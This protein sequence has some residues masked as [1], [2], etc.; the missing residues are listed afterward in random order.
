MLSHKAR[1]RVIY[2]DTDRMGY[3][4]NSNYLRWFEIGR[5]ELFRFLGLT[6]MEIETKGIFMPLSEVFCKFTTPV[7]YDDL[8]LIDT[9][10][11]TTIRAGMKF[12][13]RI[14]SEDRHITHAK[15]Y[16]K[17]ACVD[18]NGRVVRPPEFLKEVIRKFDE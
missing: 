11:D 12:D 10:L 13:Y 9:T 6:Y 15:G 2:G 18:D 5:A 14:L 7:K 1:Y 17:H 8:I 16:T 3:V 4:Y